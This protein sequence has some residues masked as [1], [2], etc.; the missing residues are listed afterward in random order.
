MRR[1][2]VGVDVPGQHVVKY[3]VIGNDKKDN[4]GPSGLS[5]TVGRGLMRAHPAR[6]IF[7]AAFERTLG[8]EGC[9]SRC[10]SLAQC[11]CLG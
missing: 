2:G 1:V 3:R 11:C 9:G 8:G 10:C 6:W 7:G 4:L 5:S